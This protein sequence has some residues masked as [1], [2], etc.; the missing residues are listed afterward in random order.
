M[1]SLELPAGS[2]GNKKS[3]FLDDEKDAHACING[4][5]GFLFQKIPHVL[6]TG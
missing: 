1:S 3:D 2:S 4:D 6:N 5:T